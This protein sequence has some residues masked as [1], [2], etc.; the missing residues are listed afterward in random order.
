MSVG[1]NDTRYLSARTIRCAVLRHAECHRVPVIAPMHVTH[2]MCT[3]NLT[4]QLID[5]KLW[6]NAIVPR[7]PWLW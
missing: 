3:V 6:I 4:L 1:G 5:R 2:S 7:F